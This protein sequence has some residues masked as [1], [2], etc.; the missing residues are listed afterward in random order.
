[1]VAS[2]LRSVGKVTTVQLHES[3]PAREVDAPEA[4]VLARLSCEDLYEALGRLPE[5]QRE[6]LVLRFIEGYSVKTVAKIL[7]KREG[8]VRAQQHRAIV[9]LR[10]FYSD[11]ERME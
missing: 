3:L 7:N 11:E 9:S 4:R 6:I 2:H 10:K 1:M 5:E 8:A